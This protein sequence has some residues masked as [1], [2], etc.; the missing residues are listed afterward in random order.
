MNVRKMSEIEL[1]P[2][3]FCGSHR[4]NIYN[5]HSISGTVKVECTNCKMEFEYEEKFEEH[6]LTDPVHP[7]IKI[8]TNCYSKTRPAFIEAWDRRADNGNKS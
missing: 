7:N 1:K 6:I 4:I 3:P 8:R 2:C 5:H